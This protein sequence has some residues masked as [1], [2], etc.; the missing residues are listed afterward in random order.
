MSR[1]VLDNIC[2]HGNY[3]LLRMGSLSMQGCKVSLDQSISVDEKASNISRR[4]SHMKFLEP[5][6]HIPLSSWRK[7]QVP[8][9]TTPLPRSQ[10]PWCHRGKM[11]VTHMTTGCASVSASG[12]ETSG[13]ESKDLKG[14]CVRRWS[15]D[16]LWTKSITYASDGV[17]RERLLKTP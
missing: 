6:W 16:Y 11:L 8:E 4:V 2:T 9:R 17:G 7:P 13:G 1:W 12:V 3:F 5:L 10:S 14:E 15:R